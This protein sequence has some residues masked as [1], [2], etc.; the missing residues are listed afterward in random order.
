MKIVGVL[1]LTPP[2][3]DIGDG[4]IEKA[5]YS[6]LALD[7]TVGG[8]AADRIYPNIA[9]QGAARPLITYQQI[10]GIRDEVLTG[11]T[12]SVNSRFQINCWA[13]TYE[14]V[15]D[16]AG[17]VRGAM[18]GISGVF[19]NVNIQVS[20]LIDEDDMPDFSSGVDVRKIY[21]KRLDFAIYFDELVGVAA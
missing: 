6:I 13:D 5:V 17:A 2:Y 18:D 20:M 1:L 21:G 12:G 7:D 15:R 9:E 19:S 14:V 4:A 3:N 16:L 8:I 11:P 10:G